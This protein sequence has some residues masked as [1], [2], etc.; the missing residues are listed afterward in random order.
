MELS[1]LDV[2]VSQFTENCCLND[3]FAVYAAETGVVHAWLN[4]NLATLPCLF[5][6]ADHPTLVPG[7][8]VPAGPFPG[9]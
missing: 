5:E 2:I 4:L 6:N 7:L 9:R 8:Y 1:D 3:A